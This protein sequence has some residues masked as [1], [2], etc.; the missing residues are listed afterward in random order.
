MRP[1]QRP[2]PRRSTAAAGHWSTAEER[3][4]GAGAEP[5]ADGLQ[6]DRVVAG[7]DPVGQLGEPDPGVNG[8]AFGPLVTVDPDLDRVR[9]VGTDLDER[10]AEVVIPE[11]ELVAGHP[12]VGLVEREPH[13]LAVTTLGRGEHVLVLLRYSDRGHARPAGPRLLSGVGAHDLDLAVV[14]A[15]RTGGTWLPSANACTAR[16]NEV[17]IFSMMAAAGIGKPR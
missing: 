9:E 11:V 2:G 10:R 8:L 7:R 3:P 14:L 13:R 4:D 17:P 15:E 16:R 5:V 12:P 1:S 6:A